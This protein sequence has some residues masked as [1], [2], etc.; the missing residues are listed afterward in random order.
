M[1]HMQCDTCE[2]SYVGETESFLKAGFSEHRKPSTTTSEVSQNQ[3][4]PNHI[5]T[6]SREKLMRISKMI[7][8]REIALIFYHCEILSTYSLWKCIETSL[9]NLYGN[10]RA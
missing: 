2:A 4:S 5:N 1:N 8:K 9:E 3:S 7:I 10:I 6:Q